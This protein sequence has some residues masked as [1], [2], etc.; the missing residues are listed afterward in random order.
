MFGLYLGRRD[1]LILFLYIF[2]SVININ[3]LF[4]QYK[5]LSL[6]INGESN[7]WYNRVSLETT[8]QLFLNKLGSITD[9]WN[10]PISIRSYCCSIKF[11]YLGSMRWKKGSVFNTSLIRSN[12]GLWAKCWRDLVSFG[13]TMFRVWNCKFIQIN[14]YIWK[15][16]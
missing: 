16:L 12:W 8:V 7:F 2:W 4:I 5:Y 14:L 6:E 15:G 13:V 11:I 1:I 9:C 10:T 3:V